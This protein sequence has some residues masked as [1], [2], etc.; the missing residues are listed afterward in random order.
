MQFEEFKII[1]DQGPE[2]TFELIQRL[3]AKIVLL[4]DRLQKIEQQLNI[5]SRNSSKPPSSDGFNKPKPKSLREKSGKPRGGQKGHEG[6]TLEKTSTPDK[7]VRHSAPRICSCGKNL[8]RVK[9]DIDTRQEFDIPKISMQVTEHQRETKCCP[10]C[11]Q[12]HHGKYPENITQPTQYGKNITAL[13][14]YMQSYQLLPAKRSEDFFRDLCG[15]SVSPATILAMQ[16]R[17]AAA[18]QSHELTIRKH[19]VNAPVLHSD[20]TGLYVNKQTM[21]MHT[22][23]TDAWTLYHVDSKRGE[24]GMNRMGILP[25]YYGTCIHDGLKAYYRYECVHGACNAHHL[26]E[27]TFAYEE[28][29]RQWAKWMKELLIKI[30]KAV[31]RKKNAGKSLLGSYVR[32]KFRDEYCAITKSAVKTYKSIVKMKI[33]Q[34]GRLRQEKSKNLLDR[35]IL[36][37]DAVLMFMDDFSVPFDNNLAERDIRMMKVKQKISG[38][39]RSLHGA[40]VFARVRGFVSTVRK[41]RMDVMTAIIDV[42]CGQFVF[43]MAE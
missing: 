25:A 2:K 18:V 36:Y 33:G 4:E 6:C 13:A 39:Y 5:N 29:G 35:L 28:E 40:Q 12:I 32:K 10:D 26:R 43:A 34:R 21:W 14:V 3:E 7:V 22:A 9:P 27:L 42:I 20:E 15:Q 17:F 23:S 30:K 16:D 24:E 37:E 38:C 1:Y 8:R 41:Q 19:L 11:G 31:D